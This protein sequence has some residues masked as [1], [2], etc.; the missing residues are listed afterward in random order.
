M[1]GHRRRRR[2]DSGV[3]SENSALNL[4][5]LGGILNLMNNIDIN[6]LSSIIQSV[7]NI[8]PQVSNQE[9]ANRDVDGKILERKTELEKALKTIVNADKTELLQVIIQ[10]YTE[11]RSQ[12][13]QNK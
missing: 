1:S 10:I 11:S 13:N 4:Q 6:Q 8:S 12:Q 9:N 2:P 5:N 7:G 3:K